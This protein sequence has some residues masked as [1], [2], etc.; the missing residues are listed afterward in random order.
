MSE[1]FKLIIS[2][3]DAFSLSIIALLVIA[4]VYMLPKAIQE[5]GIKSIGPI[6]MEQ[7]NQTLNH[8]TQKTIEEI[9]VENRENLWEATGEFLEECAI[10]SKIQCP[11]VVNSILQS[12][13][14]SIRNMIL[15][16]HIAPKLVK[17][18][19][20]DLIERLNRASLKSLRVLKNSQIPTGC[21]AHADVLDLMPEKYKEFY[22]SWIE[23]ARKITVHACK[24][25]MDVYE[26][27][28][29]VT[30]DKHWKDVFTECYNKNLAYIEGMGYIVNKRNHLEKV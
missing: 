19:E 27:A 17:E 13:S 2:N 21:P 25:K 8:V 24:K 7:E 15:L 18:K 23:L 10:N 28:L 14:D 22:P 26:E 5:M 4:I 6:K 3:L 30:K 11:A 1:S 29:K 16:N 12:I 9:D 20:A